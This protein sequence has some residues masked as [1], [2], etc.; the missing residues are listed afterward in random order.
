MERERQ[1]S[2]KWRLVQA[3]GCTAP[4]VLSLEDDWLPVDV[5]PA[6]GGRRAA[7]HIAAAAVSDSQSA[8]P[9]IYGLD[10]LDGCVHAFCL[11]ICVLC[12]SCV[13]VCVCVC[14]VCL[15]VCLCVSAVC[16]VVCVL[17][18]LVYD[19]CVCFRDQLGFTSGSAGTAEMI[20]PRLLPLHFIS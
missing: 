17:A 20:Q 1:R 13:C 15:S 16:A 18:F 3:G 8:G 4:L 12:F 6:A 2:D 9:R 14:A 19:V 7:D 10:R 5:P 11:C